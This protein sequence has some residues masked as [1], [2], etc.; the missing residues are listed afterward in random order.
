MPTGEQIPPEEIR[1]S[2][3]LRDKLLYYLPAP[4]RTAMAQVD[5]S[6]WLPAN[7]NK[8][9]LQVTY[10]P[11]IGEVGVTVVEKLGAKVLDNDILT[12]EHTAIRKWCVLDSETGEVGFYSEDLGTIK[13]GGSID[14]FKELPKDYPEGAS[15]PEQI[16]LWNVFGTPRNRDMRELEA[17][18]TQ[19]T[20]DKL[21]YLLGLFD[22]I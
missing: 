19:F 17:A 2:E 13:S 1:V 12:V 21:D 11:G 9:W 15:T 18:V 3:E 4:A 14:D 5:V 20:Q 22:Q 10:D 6:Y 16:M 7:P 8:P